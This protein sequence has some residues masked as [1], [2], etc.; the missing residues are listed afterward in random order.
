[1]LEWLKLLSDGAK[2][3]DG[4]KYK[5]SIEYCAS[6]NYK[7]QMMQ[8]SDELLSSYQ[9]VIDEMILIPGSRGI[10]DVKVNDK[11]IFSKYETNRHAEDGEMLALFSEVV[12]KAV[13]IFPQ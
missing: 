1:M 9:H 6:C 4:T 12:G 7:P 10:F 2:M 8:V 5:V 11:L 13:P 3:S